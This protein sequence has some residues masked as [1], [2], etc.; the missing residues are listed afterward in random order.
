M[1]DEDRPDVESGDTGATGRAP[2][3]APKSDREFDELDQSFA[4]IPEPDAPRAFFE[5]DDYLAEPP[6]AAAQQPVEDFGFDEIAQGDEPP[7][8]SRRSSKRGGLRSRVS[9]G[10]DADEEAPRPR[11]TRASGGRASGGRRGR[12]DRPRAA[13]IRGGGSSRRPPDGPAALLSNPMARLAV[14]ALIGILLVFGLWL[15]IKDR[16]RNQLVGSYKSYVNEA[17]QLADQSS[18][19][20]KKLI[21]VLQNTD[22]KNAAALRSEVDKLAVDARALVKRGDALS[23][24]DGLADA[25]RALQMSLRMRSSGLSLLSQ[26]IPNVMRSENA[27]AAAR[28]LS[29]PMKRFLASDVVYEDE[30]AA[31]AAAKIRQES[32]DGLEVASNTVFLTGTNDKFASDAGASTLLKEMKSAG[33]KNTNAA[34]G[35]R[36]TSVEGVTA[37]PSGQA[38]S[39][40]GANNI[41]AG[42]EL[43]WVVNVKNGGDFPESDIKVT[44]QLYYPGTADAV[45]TQTVTIPSLASGASKQVSVPGPASGAWVA[46]KEG[47]LVIESGQVSGETNTDNNR[48]EFQIVITAG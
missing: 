33:T 39:A 36:G 46:G 19:D 45:D 40:S 4:D 20:G 2:R 26:I 22:G 1:A 35:R 30:Y 31:V 10:R 24:P 28:Q 6:P 44:A 15:F 12:G 3:P 43:K 18:A 48:Q 27:N 11:R 25:D 21:Q 47:Q 32:I 23:P 34:G 16:Q 37:D 13:G 42:S 14:F 41:P 8:G 5:E 29:D 7:P 9:P 38:L 17:G